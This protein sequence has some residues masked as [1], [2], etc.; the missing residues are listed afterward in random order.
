MND[1]TDFD[2]LR[3]YLAFI[4]SITVDY[5]N[6]DVTFFLAIPY[7][8][9]EAKLRYVESELVFHGVR[10]MSFQQNLNELEVPEFYR[11]AVLD[12]HDDYKLN[13]GEKVIFLGVDWGSEYYKWHFVA[14]SYELLELSGPVPVNQ[15]TWVA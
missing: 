14:K 7:D 8:H 3:L 2:D 4:K 10:E 6:N 1:Y 5:S 15:L 11:S 12:I 9:Q 13:P